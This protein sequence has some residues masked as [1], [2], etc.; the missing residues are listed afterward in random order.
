MTTEEQ[1]TLDEVYKYLRLMKPRYEQASRAEKGALL[2]EME[3][4]TGR[5]RKSLIRRLQTPIRREPRQRERE[6][7]YQDDV[8]TAL[9]VI[10]ES[11]DYICAER[12]QPNR[13]AL[14]EQL[15][16]HGELQLSPSLK[17][18]L[19]DISVTT[20]RERLRQWRSA[21]PHLTRRPPKPR[22]SALADIPM[23]RI[24]WDEAVPGH[25]EV[26]L[27]FH[28]GLESRGEC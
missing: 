4:V 10:W 2:S 12:L 28:C 16:A 26:D 11:Y 5:H 27:V 17:T 19:A 7:T 15:A 14:A 21:A 3:Q 1:M 23:Q 13:V 9:R 25:F 22:N 8:D 6:R 24:A 18:Q 20:V